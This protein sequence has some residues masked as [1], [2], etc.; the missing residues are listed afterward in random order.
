MRLFIALDLND[1]VRNAIS[2]FCE[3]LRPLC[4]AAKWV[5]VE[6]MH[7]TLKF[8]GEIKEPLLAKIWEALAEVRSSSP[9]KMN[10]RG[11]GFFPAPKRP[12]VLW[13]GIESSPN[14]AEIAA[15]IEA[16]LE[17]LG[18]APE[19]REF[20]PHLTLARFE[21]PQG[22]NVLRQELESESAIYFGSA[23]TG[24]FCL[25]QSQSQR[26]GSRYTCLQRFRFAPGAAA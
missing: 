14:L 26:G 25:Y 2:R 23:Q 22:L 15:E 21:S 3:R 9:V 4:P 13:I 16:R 5:R 20:K 19:T 1:S 7:V 18:I 24:E 6:G 17:A 8:L 11:T 12:R 10:F